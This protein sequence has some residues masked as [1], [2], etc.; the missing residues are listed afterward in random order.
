MSQV[1]IDRDIKPENDNARRRPEV[2]LVFVRIR[3]ATLIAARRTWIEEQL[4]PRGA[5]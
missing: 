3:G 2:V 1:A 4:A 5:L